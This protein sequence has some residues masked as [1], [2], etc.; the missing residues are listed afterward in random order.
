VLSIFDAHGTNF[1]ALQ[2][3]EKPWLKEN[4]SSEPRPVMWVLL[5]NFVFGTS[6]GLQVALELVVSQLSGVLDFLGML[7]AGPQ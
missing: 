5:Q 1:N 3:C 6:E 7:E 2:W 4:E